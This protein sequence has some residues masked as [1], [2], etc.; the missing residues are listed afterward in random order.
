VFQS[1]AEQL[2]YAGHG[3]GT[4]GCGVPVGPRICCA[5]E[6]DLG[7]GCESAGKRVDHRGARGFLGHARPVR[8][9]ELIGAGSEEDGVGVG[10][11]LECVGVQVVVGDDVAVITTAVEGGIDQVDDWHGL[12][13]G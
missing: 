10:D 6:E 13:L 12:I 1:L 3:V 11:G 2:R 9:E 8:R 5:G 7:L 4:V